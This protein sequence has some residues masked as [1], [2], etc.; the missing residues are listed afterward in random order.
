[1]KSILAMG[2]L[3][4]L[5]SFFGC[6][7]KTS[8]ADY[9]LRAKQIKITE[10]K[11]ELIL[12]K[13]GKT[14]FDFIGITSN[15]IDC[16]YF[17]KDSDTFQIEFEAMSKDQIPFI[18]KLKAFA[19]ENGYKTEMTTYGNKPQYNSNEAPVLKI[20][21]NSELEETVAIGQKIQKDIFA[22]HQETLYDIVP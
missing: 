3:T 17:V 2:I 14:E 7:N 13:Q 15:G 5:L 12:L 8:N 11:E 10:L 21:T 18:D 20:R 22:N 6:G 4:G 9:S 1:M 19:T 16:I